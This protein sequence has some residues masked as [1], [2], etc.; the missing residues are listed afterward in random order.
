ML[1]Q[2]VGMSC[3]ACSQRVG[4]VIDG[5]FC[6]V[7]GNPVHNGCA[8]PPRSVSNDDLLSV[9]EQPKCARCGCDPKTPVALAVHD[10]WLAQRAWSEVEDQAPLLAASA[11]YGHQRFVTRIVLAVWLLVLCVAVGFVAVT[12]IWEDPRGALA[13]V[14]FPSICVVV[15]LLYF[16]AVG[17]DKRIVDNKLDRALEEKERA[18]IEKGDPQE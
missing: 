6:E 10:V 18:R 9:R 2:L 4:S 15:Y 3:A 14:A 11:R 17:W 7:C 13:C 12:G 16:W 1:P 8:P 5:R